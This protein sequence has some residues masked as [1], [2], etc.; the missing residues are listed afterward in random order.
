MGL[1][2]HYL[3]LPL[4][5]ICI[6]FNF[7]FWSICVYMYTLAHSISVY[8]VLDR[9]GQQKNGHNPASIFKAS[10][11]KSVLRTIDTETCAVFERWRD[12]AVDWRGPAWNEWW[13]T[14]RTRKPRCHVC[15]VPQGADGTVQDITSCPTLPTLQQQNFN[16]TW[17]MKMPRG[18]FCDRCIK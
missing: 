17:C 11:K 16:E 4:L 6:L 2:S 9:C 15:P 3:Y 18:F 12:Y 5:F 1:L 7:R 8:R 10:E 13:S 14:Y